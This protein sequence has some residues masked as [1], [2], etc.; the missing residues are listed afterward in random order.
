MENL[1][2]RGPIPGVVGPQDVSVTQYAATAYTQT[3]VDL[4]VL[5]VSVTPFS[6]SVAEGAGAEVGPQSA[7]VTAYSPTVTTEQIL[8]LNVQDASLD[9]YPVAV[10]T[11]SDTVIG[12]LDIS[13]TQ[14]AVTVDVTSAVSEQ[15]GPQDINITPLAVSVST[16]QNLT[17][18]GP[19]DVSVT[20]YAASVGIGESVGL[21]VLDASISQYSVAVTL[22]SN[23]V[24]G[25]KAAHIALLPVSA[26]GEDPLAY[27]P[28]S[29]QTLRGNIQRDIRDTNAAVFDPEEVNDFINEAISLLNDMSPFENKESVASVNATDGAFP[30]QLSYVWRVEA[31][32]TGFSETP[33][34]PPHNSEEK[35]PR[36]G[37]FF[38]NGLVQIGD[39]WWA[40]LNRFDGATLTFWG[41]E[42]RD[43][44]TLDAQVAQFQS[45]AEEFTVRKYAR[46]LAFR[47]LQN[48]RS[49]FQQWQN[50]P[51]NT[52]ISANQLAQMVVT[53]EQDFERHA[54]KHAVLRRPQEG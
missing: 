23:V 17:L 16:D 8:T 35:G 7:T 13:I 46:V 6:V 51:K 9:V 45:L 28:P 18:S 10:E 50:L 4:G 42:V 34:L 20:Q 24:V 1:D 12:P 41:Y 43:P 49:L 54:R 40:W 26:V 21:G 22:G 47:R 3:G 19:L 39:Y 2:A 44:M 38:W 52:D 30:T 33:V 5:D 25:P 27:S 11:P 32:V 48:E 53:S 29:L 15:V 14:Y 36:R 37:W 31:T